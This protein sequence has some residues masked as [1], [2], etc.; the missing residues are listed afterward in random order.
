MERYKAGLLDAGVSRGKAN[1]ASLSYAKR[2]LRARASTIAATETQMALLEAQRLLWTQ[3]QEDG[4]LSPYAV[5]VWRVHK[6]E[7]RC[8]IC[9]PMNGQ[10]ASLKAGSSY[11]GGLNPPTHPR[12]RCWEEIVDLGI[13]KCDPDLVGIRKH[14]DGLHNQKSHGRRGKRKFTRGA[15]GFRPD[16]VENL[17]KIK[18]GPNP[19]SAGFA[20]AMLRL[21]EEFP[22]IAKNVRGVDISPG[23]TEGFDKGGSP[24]TAF[25]RYTDNGLQISADPNRIT[26]YARRAWGR[27][28]SSAPPF[29]IPEVGI[30]AKDESF[31]VDI[32][33]GI[34]VHEWGHA[35]HWHFVAADWKAQEQSKDNPQGSRRVRMA[36]DESKFVEGIP[37][38]STYAETDYAESV[39]EWFTAYYFELDQG[40]MDQGLAAYI[41][42]AW[43]KPVSIKGGVIKRQHEHTNCGDFDGSLVETRAQERLTDIS[44]IVGPTG[45]DAYVKGP[46]VTRKKKLKRPASLQAAFDKRDG[47]KT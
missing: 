36:M 8:K 31:L 23:A 5:R 41:E 21:G 18:N 19:A 20:M 4:D 15:S 42:R 13:V 44:K 37:V 34:A 10:K 2:L 29:G 38:L 7:R 26:S 45:S 43:K 11:R 35:A 32:A 39:A 12:C 40:D 47:K 6:D 14:L 25:C 3:Q 24:P 28:R 17:K 30:E 16:I 27:V 9:R 22:E 33:E 1:Q 46:L